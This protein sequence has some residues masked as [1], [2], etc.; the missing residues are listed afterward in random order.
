MAGKTKDRFARRLAFR[1]VGVCLILLGCFVRVSD[2]YP[3]QITRLIYFDVLQRIAPRQFNPDL[4]VRVVDIDE[5]T[6]TKWGQWPWPRSQMAQ[7]TDRLGEYGAAAIAF[8]M[9]FAEPDRYSPSRLLQDPALAGILRV[10]ESAAN[11][12]NDVIFGDRIAQWPVVLGVAARQT[13]GGPPIAPKAGIVEIGE[14]PSAG[15]VRVAHW[16]TLTAPL[17]QDAAGIGGVN[18]SPIGGMGVVRRVPVLWSGPGGVLPGLGVEAL[19]VALGE[20]VI[21]AE[22]A[23][24]EAGIMLGA[25]IGDFLLP[26]TEHGEIWV[27]YRRDNPGLYLSAGDIMERGDDPALRAEIEGR[28]ILVGTSAAG[29]FDMRET[30]LGESVPGVSIHAQIIEQVILGD[31]LSRSDVTAALELLAFVS[32][33]IVVTVVMSSFGAVAS[34]IAGGVAA[35]VVMAISWLAFQNQSV[36]FDATFPLLGGMAN[37]GLL[38]GYLFI[39]TEREKRVIRQTFSHYVA[40]EILDEMEATGHRLQLGGESQEITVM[41]S[42]IRG[43]TPLSESVSATDLVTLLNELFSE[44]GDQ[45][46]L[47]RGTIDKFIGDAV[48]AFW[49]APLPVEDHPQRAACAALLMRRALAKFNASAMMQGRPPIA[50]ATGCATG[51]A[52]VGNIGSRSRFNY[53]VIGDVVNVAARIEQNCRHVDYD[54]LVSRSVQQVVG[55]DLALLEAGF[56]DL[57]GKS[58][59]E[60]VYVLVGDE[61][62]AATAAFRAL[63]AAHKELIAAIRGGE[64]RPAIVAACSECA[65]LAAGVEPGLEGFYL[66]LPGR[67]ADFRSDSQAGQAVFSHHG[68]S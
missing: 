18:V 59:L 3:V 37:F 67:A 68:G 60:P 62:L 27:R 49:N 30:A 65:Q 12:D 66:T 16:T 42:D 22:G 48:M 20:P 7:M 26:T 28:I 39:S 17:G 43:F 47:E 11:L 45:I 6:L 33:G 51:T 10:E 25:A 2:P 36:L 50:L 15:L 34:F 58:D 56:V 1:L 53:T 31:T 61:H 54:I 40:P 41:F 14:Q 5:R 13:D 63:Q 8:D 4:P 23:Q 29:L 64:A 9:L 55:S 19:R 38:A 57:K 52:C 32:L 46:L 35:A 24:D 21:F 44:I